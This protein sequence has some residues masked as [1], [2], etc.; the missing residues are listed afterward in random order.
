MRCFYTVWSQVCFQ[1]YGP[2]LSMDL[3]TCDIV[4]WSA[5]PRHRIAYRTV[6]AVRCSSIECP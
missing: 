3:G 2:V 4:H 6:G 1:L 5:T